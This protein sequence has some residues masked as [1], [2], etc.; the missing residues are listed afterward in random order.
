MEFPPL[1]LYVKQG[2][3]VYY[4]STAAAS[5]CMRLDF[6]A[7]AVDA[8]ASI[9]SIAWRPYTAAP[10]EHTDVISLGPTN[11]AVDTPSAT[12]AFEYFVLLPDGSHVAIDRRLAPV[13]VLTNRGLHPLESPCITW[14]LPKHAIEP[15]AKAVGMT[16][17]VQVGGARVV[18]AV[19]IKAVVGGSLILWSQPFLALSKDKGTKAHWA[20]VIPRRPAAADMLH[21]GWQVWSAHPDGV[22]PFRRI[23]D[24]VTT[25][26]CVIVTPPPALTPTCTAT[27]VHMGAYRKARAQAGAKRRHPQEEAE[28]V[29]SLSKRPCFVSETEASVITLALA[30]RHGEK[31]RLERDVALAQIV[32]M[33]AL[34]KTKEL[35]LRGVA[36]AA[37]LSHH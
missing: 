19:R 26:S 21:E 6:A 28:P 18:G 17:W 27:M 30:E 23:L 32:K 5:T 24:V 33:Q 15:D 12:V 14:T 20:H 13:R 25:A 34:L 22:G 2:M 8:V 1:P 29:V 35:E 7:P 36:L 4:K 11:A 10:H 9:A 37:V 31:M 16:L 3:A